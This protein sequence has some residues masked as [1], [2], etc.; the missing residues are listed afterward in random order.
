MY[1]SNFGHSHKKEKSAY[2]RQIED[3]NET[4]QRLAREKVTGKK[5]SKKHGLHELSEIIKLDN[6]K[7]DKKKTK[8]RTKS[9]VL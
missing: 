7:K 6:K 9:K 1:S 2:D 5:S 8:K 4:L 3:L